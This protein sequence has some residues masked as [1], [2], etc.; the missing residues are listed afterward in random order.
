MK[1]GK[2]GFLPVGLM[3][4]GPDVSG[5]NLCEGINWQR[6][7]PPQA[8]HVL[9]SFKEKNE[10]FLGGR[11]HDILPKEYSRIFFGFSGEMNVLKRDIT[12][13]KGSLILCHSKDQYWNQSI[14]HQ[15]DFSLQKIV[16]LFLKLWLKNKE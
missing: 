13:N 16:L 15:T 2:I 1:C 12:N 9:S 10:L 6:L 11:F 8:K 3:I 4:S 5:A 7:S 14:L